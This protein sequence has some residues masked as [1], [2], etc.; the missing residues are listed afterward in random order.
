[1]LIKL[2]DIKLILMSGTMIINDDSELI[3]IIELL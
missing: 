1:M 2:N 3:N